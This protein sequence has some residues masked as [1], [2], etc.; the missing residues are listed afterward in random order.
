MEGTKNSTTSKERRIARQAARLA[1]ERKFSAPKKRLP[2]VIRFFFSLILFIIGFIFDVVLTV[3]LVTGFTGA[4]GLGIIALYIYSTILPQTDL[5]LGSFFVGENSVIYHMDAETGEYLEELTIHTTTNSLW[6]EYHEFPEAL[7]LSTVAIE[8]KRFWSH[9]GVDWIRTAAAAYYTFSGTDTQGGST[10]TQQLIKNLTV[11]NDITVKRKLIEIFRAL[12][13]EQNYTKEEILQWYLNIIYLGDSNHGVGAASIAYFGKEVGELSLAESASLIAI[14]NNPTVYGPYSGYMY[15][16]STTGEVIDSRI[17]NKRRQELILYE[18]YMNSNITVHEYLDAKNEELVFVRGKGETK[19]TTIYTWFEEEVISDVRE[20]LM[21]KYGYSYE[22]ASSLLATGG[23]SIYTT[24]DQ[25]V[26]NIA[27]SVYQNWNNLNVPSTSGE[28]LQSAVTII[29]NATGS[30]VALVGQMG[31]KEKN[32]L[33]NFA[34]EAKRQPGSAIKPLSVYAPAFHFGYI[35]PTS[36]FI[37]GPYSQENGT[38]WPGNAYGYYAGEVDLEFALQNSSNAIAAHIVGKMLTPIVSF[39]FMTDVLKFDLVLS[40][41]LSGGG[42]KTDCAVAPLA[43]GGLTYGVNTRDMATAYSMFPNEGIFTESRTYTKVTN[44]KGQVI[45]DNSP[46]QRIAISENSA[47]YITELLEGVMDEGTGTAAKFD[48]M[49]MAGKTGT[50]NNKYDLWF[51]GYTPYYTAAVWTGYEYN[52][53]IDKSTDPA[54][55]MW[56]KVMEPLHADLPNIDFTTPTSIASTAY[57]LDSGHLPNSECYSQNRVAIAQLGE[58]ERPKQVCTFHQVYIPLEPE[59]V[60]PDYEITAP[61]PAPEVV[62]PP[63]VEIPPQVEIPPEI[64]IPEPDYPEVTVPE[65][66][67]I[68]PEPTI[69]EPEIIPPE[70]VAP[71]PEGTVPEEFAPAG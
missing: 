55:T 41:Y 65:P 42:V 48:G 14:T 32:L 39:Q 16:D 34:T 53:E 62:I 66:E 1:T 45:L 56:K 22:A 8:D 43:L 35:N 37:D 60:E 61:A 10:I 2:F 59:Y 51:V 7:L 26:Q 20:D 44:S 4:F 25:N 40:E 49:T 38:N 24:L 12:E 19:D 13:L 50:T 71:E 64:I 9:N 54:M 67:I 11:F 36:T 30:V 17:L 69:P 23:L 63:E 18:L 29:D 5:D 3:V 52:E 21:K 70:T 58:S 28:P 46:Q 15:T 68:P 6:K 27:D 47:H 31:T 33:F 57:C